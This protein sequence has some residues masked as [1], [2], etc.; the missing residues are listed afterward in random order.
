MGRPWLR[1]V[2]FRHDRKWR[3]SSVC[4]E[5]IVRGQAHLLKIV[6]ALGAPGCFTSRLHCGQKQRDENSDDRYHDEQLDQ[7]EAMILLNSAI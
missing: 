5:V 7:C 1:G 3:K 4:R 6:D 2:A